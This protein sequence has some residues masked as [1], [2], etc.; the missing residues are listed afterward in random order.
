MRMSIVGKVLPPNMRND[1]ITVQRGRDQFI[2]H[3]DLF[4][5]V[6]PPL[7][8]V[9]GLLLTTTAKVEKSTYIQYD[10]VILV[11]IMKSIIVDVPCIYRSND[12]L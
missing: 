6:I 3:D 11:K 4:S 2:P 8:V 10:L 5:P 1:C 12:S 7:P 9:Y